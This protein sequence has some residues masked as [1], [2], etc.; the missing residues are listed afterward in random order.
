MMRGSS[1]SKVVATLALFVAL[2]GTGYAVSQ[3]PARSVGTKQLRRNAVTSPKIA[4]ASIRGR[5]LAPGV[6]RQGPR[7]APGSAKAYV[8]VNADGSVVAAESLGAPPVDHV[9]TGRYCIGI[10]VVYGNAA[11]VASPVV[12]TPSNIVVTPISDRAN[13]V[14]AAT[15][16][17][18]AI[19]TY[20]AGADSFRTVVVTIADLRSGEPMDSAFY[21]AF[22]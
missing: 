12:T 17:R 4:D 8:R 14:T 13:A 18:D 9:A 2:G 7:G 22:N 16:D 20:C 10:T 15:T 1:Y 11:R 3:L 19:E 5:D 21:A 6:V